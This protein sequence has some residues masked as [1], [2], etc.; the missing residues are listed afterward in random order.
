MLCRYVCLSAS[1]T[2]DSQPSAGPVL[3][4]AGQQ[5]AQTDADDVLLQGKL[6]RV[7]AQQL[8]PQLA[9]GHAL[10]QVKGQTRLAGDTAA[11]NHISIH[12]YNYF[13][14]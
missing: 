2:L 9:Q 6:Q 5:L 13:F 7:E 3:E 8:Q 12:I 4:L 14:N 10:P 1:L 11:H